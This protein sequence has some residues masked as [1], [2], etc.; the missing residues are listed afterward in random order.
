MWAC[1]LGLEVGERQCACPAIMFFLRLVPFF[2]FEGRI[3]A[4]DLWAVQ[5]EVA[6]FDDSVDEID[7]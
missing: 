6:K 1:L 5:H 3:L 2:L 4:T 7:R